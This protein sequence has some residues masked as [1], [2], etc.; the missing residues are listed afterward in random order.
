VSAYWSTLVAAAFPRRDLH[1]PTDPAA[2]RAAAIELSGRG[3]TARDIA[4]ALHI[5]EA[6]VRV[7]LGAPSNSRTITEIR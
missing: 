6:A 4:A 5:S 2:L 1:R 7:L 3:L